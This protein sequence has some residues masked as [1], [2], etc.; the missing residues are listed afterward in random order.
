[1]RPLAVLLLSL[2]LPVVLSDFEDGTTGGW[3]ARASATL[4]AS[5][6]AARTGSYGLAVSG[7]AASWDGPALNVLPSMTKGEKYEISVW[8]K[9]EGGKLGLSIERR[10]GDTPTYQRIVAPTAATSWTQLKGQYTLV[11]DVDFLSLYVESDTGADPF[12]LDDFSLTQLPSKPIQDLA[13]VKEAVPF[14]MGAAIQRQQTVGREG[15]LLTR[16]FDSVTPGNQLKW[17]STEPREGEFTFA[18]GDYLVNYGVANGMHVRGHTLA[19]HSQTPA[20]VFENASKEVLLQRL[21]RHIRAVMGRYV[22][23]IDTWDVVNEVIDENQPDGLR[24]SPW[25]EITGLDFIRTAFRVAHEVDPTA[26]LVF[27][28]YNTEFPRKREAMFKVVKQL[29]AEGVPITTVGHQLHVNIEQ[30]PASQVEQTIER[31]AELGVDQQVT[32]LDVSVY[33][34]FVSSWPSIPQDVLVEQGHRYK[35]LFDVFRRQ[36]AHLSSVTTWGLADNDTWLSTFPITRLQAPLLFDDELQAKPAYWGVTDPSK[37][38]PL[39]RRLDV[40]AGAP[41][42]DGKRELEWDLLPDAA[43]P[44]SAAFHARWS[45]GGLSLLATVADGSENKTDTVTA[46]VDG[47][48]YRIQ[49]G[50]TH[51]HGFKAHTKQVEGGYRAEALLPVTAAAADVL[52]FQL[53]VR[54]AATGT[55]TS[56][57]GKLTLIPAVKLAAAARGTPVIDAVEDAAWSA[58][59]PLGKE[60]P[61]NQIRTLWD[62]GHLYV[63]ARVTDPSLSEESPNPWEQDSVE[64]FVDPANNKAKGYDDDD[65]QYRISFTGKET[66]GGTFDA[67]AIKQNLTSAARVVDGGYVVEARIKLPTITPGN[68]TLIGFDVQINDATG[69]TR[70]GSVTWNDPTGQSYLSTARWGVLRLAR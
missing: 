26:K 15:E 50:G 43:L 1:M 61:W 35:E 58:A 10:T 67:F 63:L 18:E 3:A 17:E 31:F 52:P 33:T 55:E 27:N 46:V 65:G 8:V 22:G 56:W 21:E 24:R 9:G 32:E 59:A 57:N 49:R 39:V 28:D 69:P 13:P 38:P 48:P 42:I 14:R 68:G 7:R 19:W 5:T 23:K 6:A 70:T 37:L 53:K 54:D 66:V 2:L 12:S 25:F 64:I 11:D 44:P 36:A 20:W 51:A 62:A 47:V 60:Q 40:P 4:S 29:L 30:A 16:H 34:D 45:S 41:R